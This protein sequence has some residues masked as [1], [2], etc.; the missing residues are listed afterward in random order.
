MVREPKSSRDMVI[1]WEV[2]RRDLM[3]FYYYKITNIKNGSFYIGITTNFKKRKYQHLYNLQN[4]LHL[5]YKMQKDF[6]AYGIDNFKIEVIDEFEGSVTEGYQKEYELIQLYH[7][8]NS[9]NI[10]E[11]GQI[12]PVY[13]PQCLAKIKKTHQDKYDN[14]LQYGFDGHVFELINKF[15]SL[16]DAAKM[17]NSDF[18]AIQKV[19]KNTQSHHNY[20]WVKESEKA[21]WLQTFLKRHSCCIA[22]INEPTQEIEDTALTIKEF[23]DKYNTTYNRIYASLRQNNRCE[24]KY[25]FIRITAEQFAEINNLSL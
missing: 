13:S 9:Y 19:V 24:R 14:I 1:P 16:H 22:K 25:K 23:A 21:K 11:G 20:Y 2:I 18:R 5:N 10:L 4:Q 8:T 17:T 12:N 7:A 6:D 3:K 15:G